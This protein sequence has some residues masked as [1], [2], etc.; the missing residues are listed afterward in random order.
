MR[1]TVLYDRIY[2]CLVG[3]LIGDSSAAVAAALDPRAH[4]AD[5]IGAA[6]RHLDSDTG[7]RTEL[8]RIERVQG[9]TLVDQAALADRLPVIPQARRDAAEAWTAALRT[10]EATR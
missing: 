9:V 10:M 1:D 6:E 2:G 5:L 8:A 3:A 4:V 7:M